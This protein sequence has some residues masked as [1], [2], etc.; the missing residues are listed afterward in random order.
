MSGNFLWTHRAWD[1]VT[2]LG[3]HLW[4]DMLSLGIHPY[5]LTV[6]WRFHRGHLFL[7]WFGH[8]LRPVNRNVNRNFLEQV[9]STAWGPSSSTE[10]NTNLVDGSLD[11]FLSQNLAS[12]DEELSLFVNLNAMMCQHANDTA[13]FWAFRGSA[14]PGRLFVWEVHRA[15]LLTAL[16]RLEFGRVRFV[17]WTSAFAIWRSLLFLLTCLVLQASLHGRIGLPVTTIIL[18]YLLARLQDLGAG[19]L[20]VLIWNNLLDAR[21]AFSSAISKSDLWRSRLWLYFV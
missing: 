1:W 21:Q 8:W 3:M 18:L 10:A 17:D 11:T 6:L 13:S 12:I 20:C 7:L 2:T 4:F 15:K 19:D 5:W 9:K 16:A 14:S